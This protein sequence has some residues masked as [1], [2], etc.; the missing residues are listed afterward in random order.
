MMNFTD[1]KV[2]A[3][4][5]K[6]PGE[7]RSLIVRD[8]Q[9]RGLFIEVGKTGGSFK[10]QTTARKLGP[11]AKSIRRTLG[12]TTDHTVQE[13][14]VWALGLLG[15]LRKGE[16][17]AAPKTVPTLRSLYA[18]FAEMRG[19]EGRDP[20]HTRNIMAN[21]E[22]HLKDWLALFA[23]KITAD[24]VEA[25][26]HT[27]RKGRGPYAARHTMAQLRAVFASKSGLHNPVLGL[28]MPTPDRPKGGAMGPD[29][30]AQWWQ[31]VEKLNNPIR[32][33]F[34]KLLLL[35][36]MRK[37]H[38]R[39]TRRE[40]VDLAG[41]CIRFPKLKAG[42]PFRLPLSDPMLAIVEELMAFPLSSPWLFPTFD[43]GHLMEAREPTLSHTGHDL[44]R[45][46]V[47]IAAKTAL[48]EDYRKAL[49]DHT[50]A[51]IH[52]RY[53]NLDVIFPELLAAQGV[54]SQQLL[55]VRT[56]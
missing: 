47:S 18:R 33:R 54:I 29:E 37:G 1:A 44:R 48:P 23:D 53:L 51:G 36:G 11:E 10:I 31:A 39:A 56:G 40:W 19:A 49:V 50:T 46:Y 41:R 2:K 3:L 12:R 25:R 38:L 30:L 34:H 22:L 35:S 42:R 7:A 13:A 55:T 16:H 20:V 32:Q 26:Y 17:H 45:T 27:I 14:R 24:M 8:S 15:A 5:E 52:G 21:A 6:G 28:R 9:V 43:G 4:V